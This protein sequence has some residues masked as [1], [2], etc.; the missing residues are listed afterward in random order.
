MQ[1]Y[2]P[3]SRRSFVVDLLPIDERERLLADCVTVKLDFGSVLYEPPARVKHVYFPIKGFV[4]LVK[5]LD[6]GSS[7]E[8]G[9]VGR[10]GIVGNELNTADGVATIT[11]V[12]QGAGEASQIGVSAFRKHL[13]RS[14]AIRMLVQHHTSYQL[15][16]MAQTIL[17]TRFHLIEQRLG[18]WLLMTSDRAGSATFAVTHE[19]LSYMLGARR[20]GVTLAMG[21]LRD[22][23]LILSRRSKVE[24]VDMQGL[25]AIAC[26]CYQ[27]DLEAY[28]NEMTFRE[29]VG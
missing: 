26:P 1:R 19:F 18:R 9:M 7:I 16:Q 2:L 12:V 8:I 29:T 4:S 5:T 25:E 24:I 6:D 15:R 22:Q 20:A 23:G 21:A 3:G 27:V 11:A 17:C 14:P 28:R 13:A 10:E